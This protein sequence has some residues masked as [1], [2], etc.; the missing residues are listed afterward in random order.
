MPQ[1]PLWKLAGKSMMRASAAFSTIILANPP[2]L[3]LSGC[4]STK[5]KRIDA[6]SMC[7]FL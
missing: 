3:R 7:A 5:T 4:S 2:A 1:A 6:L